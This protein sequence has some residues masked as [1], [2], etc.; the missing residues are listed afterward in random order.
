MDA[1]RI[2]QLQ[3]GWHAIVMHR[4]CA[5][6]AV[7]RAAAA[8]GVPVRDEKWMQQVGTS[9][10]LSLPFLVADLTA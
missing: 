5:S 10:H 4:Q 3:D 7:Q 2:A 9:C 8:A 1:S 6:P